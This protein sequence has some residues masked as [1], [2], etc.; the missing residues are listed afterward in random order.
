MAT[1]L[2]RFQ[3]KLFP[4]TLVLFQH[5]PALCAL[6][7][8]G[9]L[10]AGLWPFSSPRNQV[11]W[12][13]QGLRFGGRGIILSSGP[14]HLA[15]SHE[16][17]SS[18]EIWLQPGKTDQESSIL[19]FYV[20]GNPLQFTLTQWTSGLVLRLR[21][22]GR[23]A[24]EVAHIYAGEL[25]QAEKAVFITITSDGETASV[26]VNGAEQDTAHAFPL[27]FRNLQ[28]QLAVGTS[29]R[30]DQ[31]WD[32]TVLGLAVLRQMLT[33]EE[34]TRRYK[35]WTTKGC[36][37]PAANPGTVALYCFGERSG[38]LVRNAAGSGGDLRIPDRYLI[39]HKYFLEIPV[40]WNWSDIFQN[41]VGF[42]PIGFLFYAHFS[43][44]RPVRRSV[45]LT[46]LTGVSLSL[47]I[48]TLQVYLPTRDSDVTDI[49]TNTLGTVAG[50]LL[51]RKTFVS[52]F[53]AR[54][55]E[56]RES[57]QTEVEAA[58]ER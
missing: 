1:P 8:A 45:I 39:P 20:P 16:T 13:G 32:G 48:E 53:L 42:T 4:L 57:G 43:S 10:V 2:D 12:S 26:Y 55:L 6:I 3:S 22:Q 37:E 17:A 19:G 27:A 14:D 35:T 28:G 23:Q 56:L 9:I 33:P 31:G 15:D 49:V 7:V 29:P 58:Q 41:I 18:L 44:K 51:Y 46:V 24:L 54:A 34:V 21:K 50:V 5:L 52:T 25:F 38:S 40:K 30:G 11:E 36:P 47:L